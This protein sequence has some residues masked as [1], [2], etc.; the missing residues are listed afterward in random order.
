ML[1]DDLKDR[2]NQIQVI[3]YDNVTLQAQRDVYQAQLQKCEDIITH[4]RTH[5]VDHAKDQGKDN[6]V[7][8]IDKNNAPEE[9]EFYE[10]PYYIA[11]IQ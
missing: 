9:D 7:M 2:D 10:S 4:L 6:I 3:Q 5:Y 11:G 8:I 1:T